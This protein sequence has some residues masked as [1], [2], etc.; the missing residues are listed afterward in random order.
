M[1]WSTAR[2]SN[3]WQVPAPGWSLL[4][5]AGFNNVDLDAAKELGVAITRVPNYSP[6][7]VAE[8][9]IALIL[10]L[11]RKIH[12]A[13][14][15]VRE[16]NFS[17]SGLVGFDLSGKTAGILGTGKIGSI[18]GEILRGFGMQRLPFRANP[19]SPGFSAESRPNKLKVCPE[20]SQ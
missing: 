15:R 7:A 20:W 18:V 1:T 19:A 2:S 4:R 12:R 3:A 10:T 6:N 8:R 14:N 5:C 16:L 13:F 17:L 11:N 9:T